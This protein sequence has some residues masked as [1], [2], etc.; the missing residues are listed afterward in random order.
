MPIKLLSK[1]AWDYLYPFD[2]FHLKEDIALY[3]SHTMRHFS[4]AIIGI[5]LPIYIY[6]LSQN[7]PIFSSSTVI[8]GV[9]W[10][11]VYFLLR[12]LS[13]LIFTYTIGGTFMFSTLR[14]KRAI[15]VSYITLITE[16]TVLLLAEHNLYLVLL[17]GLLAG[18]NVTTYWIPYHKFFVNKMQDVD[19]H[20]GKKTGV[21]MS[22]ERVCS[23]IAPFIGGIVIYYIGFNALFLIS[24]LLLF[25]A[26]IP[27]LYSISEGSH[28]THDTLKI[29]HN[30]LLNKKYIRTTLAFGCEG[31]ESVIYAIFWP[32]LL[33]VVL[34]NFVELG[35]LNSVSLLLSSVSMIMVGKLVDKYGHKTVHLFGVTLNALM[36][37]PRVLFTNAYFFYVLDIADR[38]N[39]ALYSV[40]NMTQ[41]YEKAYRNNASD[42]II[43]REMVIHYGILLLCCLLLTV[44]PLVGA[45]RWVFGVAALLSLATYLIDLDKN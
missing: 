22:L 24:I 16:L 9:C 39:A 23:A 38:F 19:G 42:Y 14:L 15:I 20:Y 27:I 8:N 5:F 35:L 3:L 7:Y 6:N 26:S 44:L 32:V 11:L 4:T 28:T 41:T 18:L 21:R 1:H 13:T 43:Y 36:Y 29:T 10:V 31:M 33:Y 37:L 17:A 25:F 2:H 40:P 45:W 34:N 12:S 30:Y